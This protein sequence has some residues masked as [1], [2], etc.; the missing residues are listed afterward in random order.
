MALSTRVR[1][2]DNTKDSEVKFVRNMFMMILMAIITASTAS[3]HV[4]CTV[5][6]GWASKANRTLVFARPLTCS[7]RSSQRTMQFKTM[8]A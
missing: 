4:V 3:A 5:I 2:V 1:L 6:V 8:N 7:S